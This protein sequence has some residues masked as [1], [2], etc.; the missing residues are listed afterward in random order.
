MPALPIRPILL[1]SAVLM[2]AGTAVAQ[3]YGWGGGWPGDRERVASQGDAEPSRQVEVETYRAADAGDRLGKGRIVVSEPPPPPAPPPSPDGPPAVLSDAPDDKLPVYE[4]A[5]IDQLAHKG[6]D[7]ANVNGAG[8]LVE[9]DVTH[10]VVVPEEARHKPVSG[11]M[12]VGVS[13]RGSG[14]AL[15]L[16]VDLSKPRKAIVATRV[17]VRI[18]DRATNRVLWEGHAEGQ[19]RATETGYNDGP[20][21]TRLAGVLFAKFPEGKIVQPEPGMQQLGPVEGGGD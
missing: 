12:A 5:V 7:V 11:E 8:Q 1:A 4:A 16:N 17:V 18:R 6:Y 13:N 2:S 10:A 20:T 21:A 19:T 9:V 14:Y 15:A 3:P